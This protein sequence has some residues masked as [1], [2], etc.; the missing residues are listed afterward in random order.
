LGVGVAKGSNLEI[1]RITWKECGKE[2]EEGRSV[3]R[4]KE[5]RNVGRKEFNLK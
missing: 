1:E 4:I 2:R 5:G 3:E